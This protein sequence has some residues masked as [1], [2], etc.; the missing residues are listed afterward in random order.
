VPGSGGDVSC[1]IQGSAPPT[2]LGKNRW[3]QAL[4]KALGVTI[5]TQGVPSQSYLAKFQ[6][7]LAGGDFPDIVLFPRISNTLD[8]LDHSF[9]NLTPYLSGD[10]IKNYPG[11]ASI[12][13][14]SWQI[15]TVNGQIWGMPQSRPNAGQV[16]Y[17]RGDVLQKIGVDPASVKIQSGQDFMDFCKEAT[18]VKKGVYALGNPPVGWIDLWILEMMGAPNGWAVEDGKFTSVNESPQFPEMLNQLTTIWKNG[19]CNPDMFAHPDSDLTYWDGG[20]TSMYLASVVALT[21]TLGNPT[22]KAAAIPPPKWDGGGMAKKQ[23]GTAG[24]YAFA[25]IPKASDSRVK[26]LLEICNWFA[27]PF[28]TTEYLLFNYGVKDVDYTLNGTD[29]KA[30]D[31]AKG[32]SLNGLIYVCSQRFVDLYSPGQPDGVKGTHSYLEQVLP[33]AVGNASWGLYSPTALSKAEAANKALGEVEGSIIQG[34]KP[35][36]AWGDA[37]KTW[38]KT[39]GNAMR[40]E[41]EKAYAALH[42]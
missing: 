25:A 33:D 13:T 19:W 24:Y 21:G 6:V 22:Y 39:A 27:S 38:Q 34:R 28:G 17:Y 1:L 12:P 14:A 11:L 3:W 20:R 4:N 18:N 36:S 37:L 8:I 15:P 7:D 5:Q 26:E 30:T 41:Y 29:P 16:A 32:E 23:L 10:N 40:D 31:T 42:S 35:A 9:A 2:A